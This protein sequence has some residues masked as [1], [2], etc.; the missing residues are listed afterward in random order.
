MLLAR[1]QETLDALSHPRRRE[2]LKYFIEQ[3]EPLSPAQVAKGLDADTNNAAYHIHVLKDT[4]AVR[5]VGERPARNT[6]EHFYVYDERFIREPWVRQ[7]LG[8]PQLPEDNA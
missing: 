5:F 3:A 6:T 2:V 4:W 7:L 1:P 8:L